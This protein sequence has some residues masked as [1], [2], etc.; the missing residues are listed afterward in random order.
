[1]CTIFVS[2]KQISTM[3][4]AHFYI[5]KGA[6]EVF[7]TLRKS[8][9]VKKYNSN[10]QGYMTCEDS[11]VCTL[12]QDYEVAKA[13][14]KGV[15]GVDCEFDPESVTRVGWAKKE[16]VIVLD[17]D[18]AAFTR[19]KYAGRL[20]LD[21]VVEDLSYMMWYNK[22]AYGAEA[23]AIQKL[24]KDLPLF[25]DAVKAVEDE[26]EAKKQAFFN[27]IQEIG[28]VGEQVEVDVFV[29]KAYL[30]Y[31]ME[32]GEEVCMIRGYI[33][34]IQ[35]DRFNSPYSNH[36]VY[37]KL[38]DFKRMEYRGMEY[39][40][41]IINGKAKR[42]KNKVVKVTGVIEKYE[43]FYEA[44]NKVVDIANPVIKL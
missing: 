38:T 34:E 1:M 41:P 12:A 16:E 27:S 20:V 40:M 32:H 10:G 11:H 39:P 25:N 43:T 17:L 14:A 29:G 13:K 9:N 30:D 6:Q 37:M 28:A 21:I 5:S 8:Q 44:G 3:D 7:Y 31:S 33:G 15:T 42:I 35:Y 22:N 19:G 24:L 18:T 2:T 4:S 26:Q 23:T 36:V